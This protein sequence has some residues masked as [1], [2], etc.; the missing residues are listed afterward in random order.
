MPNTFL[1]SFSFTNNCT[2][3][4]ADPDEVAA[5]ILESVTAGKTDF[6]VAA[7]F[8]AKAAMWLKFVAPSFLENTLV[9]RFEKQ[10]IQS[11]KTD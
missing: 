6:V 9:K 5:T 10:A 4:G 11:K 1:Y 7:T 2:T 3:K 8:S